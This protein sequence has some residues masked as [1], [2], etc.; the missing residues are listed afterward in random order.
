MREVG[1]QSRP[2]Y[3]LSMRRRLLLLGLISAGSIALLLVLYIYYYKHTFVPTGFSRNVEQVIVSPLELIDLQVN[4]YYFAG[5]TNDTLYLA[6]HTSPHHLLRIGIQNSS[7][8]IKADE[9]IASSQII[10]SD[11]GSYISDLTRFTIYGFN[12]QTLVITDTVYKDNLFLDAVPLPQ[13]LVLR[14]IDPMLQENSFLKLKKGTS[15]T[16]RSSLLEKQIDGIFCTDGMLQYDEVKDQLV[17]VYYYRNQFIALNSEL[18][19]LGRYH[20]IDTISRAAITVANTDSENLHQLSSPPKFINMK[21]RVDDGYL[22]IHSPRKGENED[23]STFR[24]SSAIDIYA[25]SNGQYLKSFYIPKHNGATLRD[26][27]VRH[28]QLYVLEG[29]LLYIYPLNSTLFA[30]T[31]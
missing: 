30:V 6:N 28:H 7:L 9:R 16:F 23:A 29:N 11:Q 5:I 18:T 17:F 26:F 15:T 20:T 1:C 8:D 13:G 25:V 31:L 27:I 10:I 24:H 2:F 3:L 4:S 14:D 22:Y 19:V 21:S 12:P